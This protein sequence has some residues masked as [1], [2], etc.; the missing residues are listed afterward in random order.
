MLVISASEL[1]QNQNKFFE[2]ANDQRVI[3]KRKNRFFQIVD[4]GESIPELDSTLM[5]Q[6]ELYAKIDSGIEEYRSGKTK[7]LATDQIHSFLGV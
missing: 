1:T 7:K 6:E 2:M 5:T 3:I 4:L